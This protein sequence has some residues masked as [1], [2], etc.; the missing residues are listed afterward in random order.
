[1]GSSRRVNQE[2]HFRDE[3]VMRKSGWNRRIEEDR[4]IGE[5][6]VRAV[7]SKNSLYKHFGSAIFSKNIRLIRNDALNALVDHSNTLY[8]FHVCYIPFC[9]PPLLT[10]ELRNKSSCI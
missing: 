6:E 10:K 3:V 7:Q 5:Q 2:K 4:K 8:G 1:M 9:I